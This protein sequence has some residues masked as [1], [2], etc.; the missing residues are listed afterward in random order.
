MTGIMRSPYKFLDPYEFEDHELFFGRDHEIKV[1]IAD[2]VT[3]RLVVLFAKTGTGKT[4][5]INAGVRP[6]LEQRGYRTFFIRL[7]R[8][9]PIV[10]TRR[11]VQTE[12][13]VSLDPSAP[14]EDQ[15]EQLT[16]E[17]DQPIVLFFDQFEEFFLYVATER[18][19]S[20]RA[21]VSAVARL[22]ANRHSGVHVV[23][24]MR[25][26]FL[27]EM[28][29]FR[30][31]IPTIFHADSNLRLRWFTPKQAA[32]AVVGPAR[33]LGIEVEPR[34][35]EELIRDLAAIGLSVVGTSRDTPIEPAQL[36][37]VCD[38]LWRERGDL[39]ITLDDYR[40]HIVPDRE[41]SAA[42][43]ILNDRLIEEFEKLET[44][45]E[46]DLLSRLLPALH[47]DRG[48]KWVREVSELARAVETDESS[49]RTLLDRL[50][51]SGFLDVVTHEGGDFVEL[52]HDYLAEPTRAESLRV[53]A[54]GIWPRRMLERSRARHAASG[55]YATQEELDAIVGE[56]EH[57]KLARSEIDLLFFSAVSQGSHYLRIFDLLVDQGVDAIQLLS[58][59]LRSAG[60]REVSNAAGLLIEVVEKRPSVRA[61]SF[62]LLRAMLNDE[63]HSSEAQRA[64][65]ALA[66]TADAE[67][68]QAAT[69]MLL[70][71][72]RAEI[73]TDRVKSIGLGALA[74][75][76]TRESV[77]LL[78][79]ALER[80]ETT[81][82][83]QGALISLL[84]SNE[85]REAAADVLLSFVTQELPTGRVIPPT[86]A[87]LG[88]IPT[89]RVIDILAAALLNDLY[90]GVA[91]SALEHLASSEQ[92][93]EMGVRARQLLAG[94]VRAG[95]PA[96]E[97]HDAMAGIWRPP[98]Q[99]SG[100]TDP[101]TRLL[102]DI[103]ARG[104]CVLLL[105]PGIHSVPPHDSPYAYRGEAPPTRRELAHILAA[106]LGSSALPPTDDTSDLG[107]VALIYELRRSRSRL[108]ERIRRAVQEGK[109]PSAMVRALAELDFPIVITLNYDRLFEE[110]LSSVNKQPQ[111]SVYSPE[112]LPTNDPVD[113]TWQNP[114]LLKL[115]GDLGRPET[116][117]ITEED[118]S[119]FVLRMSDKEPYNPIP[120]TVRYRLAT[121]PL[122]T[123]GVS[124]HDFT[125]R[126][127]FRTLTWKLDLTKLPD[128]YVVDP[129]PDPVVIDIWQNQ[130]RSVRF[131]V[132]DIWSLVPALYQT[133]TGHEM[134]P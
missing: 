115:Y 46:L 43:Q 103:I 40:T 101:E 57:L 61:E 132:Q 66:T 30:D 125:M 73:G 133:V 105:G 65:R 69:A 89:I 20:A 107:H 58:D 33:I 117:V 34:L 29:F 112:H 47:T 1:L 3:N 84:S 50:Q 93:N 13:G 45:D 16:H 102:A 111:V 119:V 91:R 88:G 113:V 83:A 134:P 9:D 122:L 11:V 131:V 32:A 31:E 126:L 26:E 12:C 100:G 94:A 51:N 53:G 120:M 22:H 49:L 5:L 59:G 68:S 109:R 121:W 14:L 55:E 99:R 110:A 127:F 36:Q 108:V 96:V 130:R 64:L 129:Y 75:I 104:H 25:E 63:Q 76:R 67:V 54:R 6:L 21:L 118:Y 10:A 106:E 8:D 62:S 44:K 72:V 128:V 85:T 70:D 90:R 98:S 74:E 71:F 87:A 24:A 42:Q 37:V 95:L 19:S 123:I 77:A 80:D 124:L 2:V 48:T 18:P 4:S 17:L 38:T 97:E 27:A 114:M 35:V 15:L 52:V 78:E 82:E 39:R 79:H 7:Q 60:P 28:E 81:L 116:I 92:D 56:I 23:F 41:Q 86:I